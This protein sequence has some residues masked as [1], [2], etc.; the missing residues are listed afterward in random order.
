M[1][2]SCLN[3]NLYPGLLLISLLATW[4]HIGF[5]SLFLGWSTWSHTTVK[6]I[7]IRKEYLISHNWDKNTFWKKYTKLWIWTYISASITLD[8][9][10]Y[11]KNQSINR[12][13]LEEWVHEK[14]HAFKTPN[15]IPLGLVCWRCRTLILTGCFI[16]QALCQS[17][18]SLV[19]DSFP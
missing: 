13:M 11:R 4:W 9:L 14:K 16:I 8:R 17:K 1:K 19:N 3:I 15:Y 5:R 12:P 10:I 6:I 18:L 2:N 7:C